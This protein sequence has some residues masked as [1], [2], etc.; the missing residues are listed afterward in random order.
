MEKAFEKLEEMRKQSR[1]GG[2][3]DRIKKQHESGKLTARERIEFFLDPGTFQ[4][5]GPFVTHDCTDFGMEEKRF[6]EME[7][8]REWG[9][10]MAGSFSSLPKTSPFLVVRSRQLLLKKFVG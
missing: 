1:L 10:S 6:L 9:E 8:S 2:G 7:S 5:I 3:A 4:E